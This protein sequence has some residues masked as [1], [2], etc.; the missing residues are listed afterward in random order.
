MPILLALALSRKS[1]VAQNKASL[2]LNIFCTNIYILQN[3]QTKIIK[4]S[5]GQTLANRT[6]PGPSFQL[7]KWQHLAMQLLSNVATRPN[8]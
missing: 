8:L 4:I 5:H 2:L 1:L 6:N 7:Y 3:V